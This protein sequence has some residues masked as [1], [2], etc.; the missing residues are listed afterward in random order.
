[1][2]WEC[3]CVVFF[4]E[5]DVPPVMPLVQCFTAGWV[6][7]S[8]GMYGAFVCVCARVVEGGGEQGEVSRTKNKE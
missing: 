2:V 3:V 1:M 7:V 4:E 5:E 8:S 6:T